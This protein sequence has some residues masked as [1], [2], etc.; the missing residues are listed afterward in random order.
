MASILSTL[1]FDTTMIIASIFVLIG[2][3]YCKGSS[4]F[5]PA[6]QDKLEIKNIGPISWES[7]GR[8]SFDSFIK[9]MK[10]SLS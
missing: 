4:F 9:I 8:I 10:I 5:L 1:S 6:D 7:K 3:R 2:Y